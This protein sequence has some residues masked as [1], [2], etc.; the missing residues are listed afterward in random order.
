MDGVTIG[1]GRLSR[2]PSPNRDHV[3]N[4]HHSHKDVEPGNGK[5]HSSS[6]P[7]LPF[8]DP[9]MRVLGEQTQSLRCME[10][11]Y[12]DR[13]AD[14]ENQGDWRDIANIMDRLFL[15]LYLLV[16]IITTLAFLM[17]CV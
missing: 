2:D 8:R 14:E 10:R 9:I 7:A 15:I 5:H 4:N 3:E 13:E 12:R 1:K 17:Q 11:T 16:T 6:L